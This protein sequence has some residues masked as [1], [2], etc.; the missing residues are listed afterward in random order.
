[1][2][3]SI[4]LELTRVCSLNGFYLLVFF[5]MK[6][7]PSF[8]SECVSLSLL[9]PSFTFDIWYVLCVC[10]CVL[11]WFPISLIVIFSLCLW[12]CRFFCIYIYIY[13]YAQNLHTH[14][15]THTHTYIYVYFHLCVCVCVCVCVCESSFIQLWFKFS[16]KIPLLYLK[17]RV[18]LS[19]IY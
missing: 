16:N 3:Y 1:M 19:L 13:I 14:T 18:V 15:H 9:Y 7:G 8:F 2:Q 11:E 5:F 6:A 17:L 12:M 4:R 10:V